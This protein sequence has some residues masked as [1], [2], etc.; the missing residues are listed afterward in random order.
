MIAS[1][2]SS[3]AKSLSRVIGGRPWAVAVAAIGA[4]AVAA[5]A[6]QCNV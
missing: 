5:F 3:F 4:P 2:P 6:L 1:T